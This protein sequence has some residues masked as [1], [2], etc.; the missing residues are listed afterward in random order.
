MAGNTLTTLD[1]Y[2]S[3]VRGR[4]ARSELLDHPVRHFRAGGTFR[5][6]TVF[7][8]LCLRVQ[9]SVVPKLLVVHLGERQMS[10]NFTCRP[11]IAAARLKL[12][13]EGL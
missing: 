10:V 3:D 9:A 7:T 1:L 8:V 11:T 13:S 12:E 6:G 5:T 2:H 4:P